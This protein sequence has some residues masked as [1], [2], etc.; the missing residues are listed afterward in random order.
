M[1]GNVREWVADWYGEYSPEAEVDPWGPAEGNGFRVWPHAGRGS[2][3]FWCPAPYFSARSP[4]F[5]RWAPYFCAPA[6]Y[7]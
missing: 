6:P 7:F 5:S 4:Y 2:P 3:Y 1:H